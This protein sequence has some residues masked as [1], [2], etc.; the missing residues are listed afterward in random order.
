MPTGKTRAWTPSNILEMQS[1]REDRL[2][3]RREDRGVR[4]DDIAEE[5][6]QTGEPAERLQERYKSLQEDRP[7]DDHNRDK[8][9]MLSNA[10][11]NF[12][13]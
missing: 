3:G 5:G 10:S 2:E 8:R 12:L 1:S 6:R 7:K 13:S 4:S 11:E 9:W